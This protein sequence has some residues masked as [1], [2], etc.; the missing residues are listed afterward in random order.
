MRQS[1]STNIKDVSRCVAAVC[2]KY[3]YVYQLLSTF[4]PTNKTDKQSIYLFIFIY[5]VIFS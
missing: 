4:S 3:L 5:V 2:V 1:I